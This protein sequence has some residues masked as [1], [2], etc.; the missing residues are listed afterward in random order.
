MALFAQI[1]AW[2]IA[3]AAGVAAVAAVAGG[4]AWQAGKVE[5][6]Q[7]RSNPPVQVATSPP[8]APSVM[9]K[10]AAV[11]P[12]AAAP[13][14]AAAAADAAASR[15]V[16]PPDLAPQPAPMVDTAVRPPPR[17]AAVDPVPVAPDPVQQPA[18]PL[19]AVVA[20]ALPTFDIVRVEP[21]GDVL[22]AG[23]GQPGANIAV[24]EANKVL[25]EGTIDSGGQF[26][27]LPSGLAAGS[28]LLA[29]RM[30]P[31]KGNPLQSAQ[32]VAVALADKASG[33]IVVALAEPGKATEVL[34]APVAAPK[35]VA[36]L[37]PA[38]AAPQVSIR[39][40][41]VEQG[42]GFFA[43]GLAPAGAS[44]RVYLNGSFI[45][46]LQAG[47]NGRWSLKIAKGMQPGHYAVR[48]DQ[49]EPATGAVTARAEVPFD[50]PASAEVAP[51]APRI[52][53]DLPRQLPPPVAARPV[54]L[55]DPVAPQMMANPP[56]PATM[57]VLAP[58]VE[59]VAPVPAPAMVAVA[60]PPADVILRE[61]QTATVVR[62]DSLWRISR[63]AWGKGIRYT[64]IYEANASQIQNPHLIFP[65][66][67][68]VV[69]AGP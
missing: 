62:G 31:A 65:G 22:V 23:R 42:G 11:E 13:V 30:T 25:A 67:V 15:T 63:Q 39:T 60:G 55:T 50:F 35:Q 17:V 29:L 56:P 33:G 14:A 9:P 51:P 34:S 8:L 52:L 16:V 41:E 19:P 48:A 7:A 1:P 46:A 32:S 69:P 58:A 54:P 43:T 49:V 38:P 64:Q 18:L 21:P 4:L 59:T 5:P 12:V 61:I 20:A 40:V 24:V 26:V 47:A 2:I 68:L 27:L 57:P 10:P 3:P 28:H 53:A 45:A 37:A 36:L 66:Q 6:S 44:V